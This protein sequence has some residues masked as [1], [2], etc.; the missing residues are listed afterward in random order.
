MHCCL[1][2]GSMCV[3]AMLTMGAVLLG[4]QTAPPLS[5]AGPATAP[6]QQAAPQAQP[7]FRTEV[8]VVLVDA[9][10]LD[11]QGQPITG[12]TPADFDVR[13]DGK[14]RTTLSADLVEYTRQ[15]QPDTR[16]ALAAAAGYS[17]NEGEITGRAVL[18]V[19]DMLSFPPGD[20]RRAIVAASEF[21]DSL[22]P[23]DRVA[24]GT[25]PFPDQGIGFTRDVD[26]VR[27][28][29]TGL[30][31]MR[32]DAVGPSTLGFAEVLRADRGDTTAWR[33]IVQR[34]CRITS[35]APSPFAEGTTACDMPGYEPDCPCVV[36]DRLRNEVRA[37]VNT[38]RQDTNRQVRALLDLLEAL[39][40]FRGPKIVVV[41]SQGVVM[42]DMSF[43]R[44]ALGALASLADARVSVLHVE[45]G[46]YDASSSQRP[47]ERLDD[48]QL[49]RSGLEDMSALLG[50]RLYRAMGQVGPQLDRIWRETAASWRLAVEAERGDLDG[51]PHRLEVNVARK[52]AVVLTRS[53]FLVDPATRQG[54]SPRRR[55]RDAVMT[56]MPATGLPVRVTHFAGPPGPG[57]TVRVRI[58]GEVEPGAGPREVPQVVFVV[59][60]EKNTQVAAGSGV[61]APLGGGLL[62]FSTSVDLPPGRYHLRLAATSADGR[63]GSVERPLDLAGPAEAGAPLRLASD[64]LVG[65]QADGGPSPSVSVRPTVGNGRLGAAIELERT[66]AAPAVTFEVARSPGETPLANAAAEVQPVPGG[67]TDVAVAT[68]PVDALPDGFYVARGVVTRGDARLES[69]WRPFRVQ[70][71]AETPRVA[72]TLAGGSGPEAAPAASAAAAPSPA[73]LVPP[74]DRRAVLSG[75]LL[76]RTLAALSARPHASTA[77]MAGAL[78][79]AKQGRFTAAADSLTGT[80]DAA[81]GSMLRGMSLLAKARLDEAATAFRGVG[82]EGEVASLASVY[83]GAAYAS[84]GD[85]KEAVGAWREA[86][87]ALP[88]VPVLYHMLA[89]SLMRQGQGTA[90]AELLARAA[91][92][93]P[94]DRELTRRHAVALAAAE[95]WEAALRDIDALLAARPADVRTGCLGFRLAI[96]AGPA[97]AVTE[98]ART[99]YA[100]ACAAGTAPES[101]IA[102]AWLAR[103]AAPQNP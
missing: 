56:A 30:I 27:A 42:D 76:T 98:E 23:A 59:T 3:L 99:R 28:R 24:V 14:R 33:Q 51:K 84:G 79:A 15:A 37:K 92:R 57:G 55:L 72:A 2:R 45:A 93:W 95:Q 1:L 31:G 19:L 90:A 5:A 85:E 65:E 66:G 53:Y 101:P 39:R 54:D 103:G 87:V 6:P 36:Q 77:P 38:I 78:A 89:D 17:T 40:A 70:A 73:P 44:S 13:V 61:P 75:A 102:A 74:F 43:P 71:G 97:P 68:I 67:D 58:V 100:T 34:E 49:A 10:V 7:S 80:Y 64:L 8:D 48:L 47:R 88:D 63:V 29:I 16:A 91:A 21:L 41:I 22:A 9:T 62:G 81:A 25:L 94:E 20:E 18:L 35:G 32:T 11:G 26:K 82:A 52:D 12:L 60:N 96:E 4:T 83:L 69:A 46:A 50:G 86:L